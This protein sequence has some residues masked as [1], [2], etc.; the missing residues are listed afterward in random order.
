M[1]KTNPK[2]GFPPFHAT[3]VGAVVLLLT[4]QAGLQVFQ[5]W[6]FQNQAIIQEA[7]EPAILIYLIISGIA[8]LL[9]GLLLIIGILIRWKTTP[10]LITVSTIAYSIYYWAEFWLIKNGDGYRGNWLF[11]LIVNLL[12]ILY[13]LWGLGRPKSKQY[14][15]RLNRS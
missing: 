11:L 2:W 15:N 1:A 9:T 3:I 6:T 8:W 12:L 5:T 10:V 13:I 7:I 14:F 4:V